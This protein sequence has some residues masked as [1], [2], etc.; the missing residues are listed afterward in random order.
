M[1]TAGSWPVLGPGSDSVHLRL[2]FDLR[3]RADRRRAQDAAPAARLPFWALGRGARALG[4]LRAQAQWGGGCLQRQR[5]ELGIGRRRGEGLPGEGRRRSCRCG[6]ATGPAGWP[7]RE[8]EPPTSRLS[9]RP[10]GVGSGASSRPLLP[11]SLSSMPSLPLGAGSRSLPRGRFL[12]SESSGPFPLL[13][14]P[15]QHERPSSSQAAP[16]PSPALSG[17][18]RRGFPGV[19]R[20]VS[21]RSAHTPWVDLTLQTRS[22][23]LN[24]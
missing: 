3:I 18:S 17:V 2:P 14:P 4:P 5:S 9:A 23:S 24:Y 6:P 7:R 20:S 1:L 21:V 12:L 10:A 13:S 16:L 8:E 22:S 11:S 19:S 15:P